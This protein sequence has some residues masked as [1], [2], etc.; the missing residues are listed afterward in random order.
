MSPFHFYYSWGGK[1]CTIVFFLFQLQLLGGVRAI[2]PVERLNALSVTEIEATIQ[3][4]SKHD[5]GACLRPK[6]SDAKTSFK[7]KL[8]LFG[9]TEQLCSAF[10]AN[11]SVL[12]GNSYTGSLTLAAD[13]GPS[14]FGEPTLVQPTCLSQ[15]ATVGSI[16]RICAEVQRSGIDGK[17]KPLID[18]SAA[19][20]AR[21]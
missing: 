7:S 16:G 6:L 15:Q 11:R 17:G 1:A 20:M 2:A 8:V 21:I 14:G 12:V 3:L 4:A 5:A 13:M 19:V 9:A 10:E 18:A